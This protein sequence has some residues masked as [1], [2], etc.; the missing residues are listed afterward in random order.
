M[1]RRFLVA[2]LTIALSSNV[3][4][5]AGSGIFV[6]KNGAIYFTDTRDG[7]R[8]IDPQG[9]TTLISPP[10]LHW[11]TIDPQGRFADGPEDLGSFARRTPKGAKP[12]LLAAQSPCTMGKDGNF[13]HAMDHSLTIT[14]TTPAGQQS[15]FVS[16]DQFKR[17]WTHNM[18]VTAM[19]CGPDGTLYVV[20]LDSFNRNE[21]AGEHVIW[22]V[23]MDKKIAAFAK[24]FVKDPLPRDQQD[25][26]VR[27]EFCRGLA[28]DDNG[29]VYIAVTGN[30]CVMKLTPKGDAK[31][32]HKMQKPWI[33]TGV[34][35]SKGNLF[36][37]EYDGET[38][39][40]HGAWQP[41]VTK[42]APDGAVSELAKVERQK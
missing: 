10:G 13:Y 12:A 2:A 33:P 15:V 41:R 25:P 24:G 22:S 9:K 37:L 14:R 23:T 11:M 35:V 5:H 17:D 19:A 6:D 42:V 30:R 7:I 31:I 28:V 40:K 27:P 32:V 8:R 16:K 29:D 34:A 18:G 36:V 21:G 20:G 4:A 26:E 38:P 39:V 1:L 3:Y